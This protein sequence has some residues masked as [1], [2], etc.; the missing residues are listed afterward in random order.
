MAAGFVN[1][2]EICSSGW[3]HMEVGHCDVSCSSHPGRC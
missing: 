3:S 1:Q 2:I